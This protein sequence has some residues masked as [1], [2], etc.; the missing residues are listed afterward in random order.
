MEIEQVKKIL[1]L[2]ADGTDP[3]TGE[4]Y[5]EGSPYHNP[6]T[7]RA[8]YKA[9]LLIENSQLGVPKIK[10]PSADKKESCDLPQDKE[11]FEKLREIR[12][13]IA[14]KAMLPSYCIFHNKILMA[15]SAAKPRDL[16]EL[17]CIKGIGDKNSER[18][19]PIFLAVINGQSPD[20]AIHMFT[21]EF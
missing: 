6:E 5:P 1:R 4:I 7:I 15:M 3:F 2:L 18:Y 10:K 9:L 21:N 12:H 8:L 16:S 11:L 14:S 17:K 19:G 20:N 13:L